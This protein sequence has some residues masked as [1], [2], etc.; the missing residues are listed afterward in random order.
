M[1]VDV[2][3][4][5]L[6]EESAIGLVLAELADP[7]IRTVWVVDNGSTDRTAE[8]ARVAGAR[9]VSEPRRGYGSACLAGLAA[10][11]LSP[12]DVVLFLDGDHSDFPAEAGL[13]LDRIEAGVDLVI[14]SRNLGGAEA[15]SLM[16]VARF[17]NWLS[18]RLIRRLY[19]V[20]FTDLGPFRAIRWSALEKIGMV[21]RDFGWTV[22]MQVRAARLGLRCEE[23]SVRYRARIGTS[24]VSGTVRGSYRAG[25]KILWVI[26]RDRVLAGR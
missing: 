1:T 26:A 16:P 2:V 24:K 15:G 14:G 9:V 23:V 4:P 7:R 11:R 8:V 22:E 20:S 25:K 3:I 5:V 10:C 21:D 6:N 19:G 17:G 13:L 12:P 18:T